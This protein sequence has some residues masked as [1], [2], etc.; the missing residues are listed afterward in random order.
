MKVR[1]ITKYPEST[2]SQPMELKESAVV[3]G[4]GQTVNVRAAKAHLSQLLDLVAAG[5]EFIITSDGRPKARVVPIGLER[6]GEGFQPDWG[7][8][9]SMPVQQQGPTA[10]EIIRS[11]RDGRGW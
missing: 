7:L 6:R 5:R 3:P 2:I 10:Q 8:L 9:K 11:D 1:K 4:L